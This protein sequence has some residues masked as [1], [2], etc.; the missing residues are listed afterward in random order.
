M[1]HSYCNLPLASYLLFSLLSLYHVLLSHKST[2]K[3]G[4]G[5]NSLPVLCSQVASDIPRSNRHCHKRLVFDILGSGEA[6]CIAFWRNITAYNT[7]GPRFLLN[8]KGLLLCSSTVPV[9]FESYF[10]CRLLIAVVIPQ[11]PSPLKITGK[12]H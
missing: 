1:F 6:C 7:L 12:S 10:C 5:K 9:D 2:K 11:H 8:V 4:T 3:P